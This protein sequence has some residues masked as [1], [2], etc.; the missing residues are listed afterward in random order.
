[1]GNRTRVDAAPYTDPGYK[2]LEH[3]PIPPGVPFRVTPLSTSLVQPCLTLLIKWAPVCPTWQ[4]AVL[5]NSADYRNLA[6]RNPDCDFACMSPSACALCEV[7]LESASGVWLWRRRRLCFCCDCK[8]LRR[9]Q[10][11][12]SE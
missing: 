1:M 10:D 4:D 7:P 11:Q 8:L 6:N 9:N 2:M 5:L 12:G 3:L